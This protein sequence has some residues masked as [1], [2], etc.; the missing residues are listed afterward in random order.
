MIAP[1]EILGLLA[2]W[3]VAGAVVKSGSGRIA[4]TGQKK[5]YNLLD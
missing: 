1:G 3:G 5:S 2:F 4:M